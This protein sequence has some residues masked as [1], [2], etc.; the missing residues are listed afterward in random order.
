MAKEIER[1]FLLRDE[2]WRENVTRSSEIRDGFICQQDGIKLRVR[3]CDGRATLTLK[4]PRQGLARDEFEYEIPAADGRAMLDR[5]SP[6]GRVEKTRHHVFHDG[7]AW[8][9]DEFA[10]ALAG[11]VFCEIELTTETQRFPR[12]PWLGRE[13]T[14]QRAY[15]QVT[16]LHE[17]AA[18]SLA[19]G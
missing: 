9:V 7:F 6:F 10:G 16:L 17:A 19:A 11:L 18:R 13:V 12:P 15:Q 4:G 2:R 3:F 14:G 5:L 1:K 8:T